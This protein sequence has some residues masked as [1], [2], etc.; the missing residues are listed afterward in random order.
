M[1]QPRCGFYKIHLFFDF[2]FLL[3]HNTPV[4]IMLAAR[5]ALIIIINRLK[6]RKL[7]N[8]RNDVVGP[9]IFN[10]FIFFVIAIYSFLL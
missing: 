9:T 2:L 3:F 5:I 7:E 8:P 1:S 4:K 6:R 10:I